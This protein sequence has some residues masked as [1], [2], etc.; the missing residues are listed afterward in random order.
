MMTRL[1]FLPNDQTFLLLDSPFTAREVVEAVRSGSWVPP[2]PYSTFLARQ[3]EQPLLAF[4]Q[5]SLVIITTT[6]PLDLETK[7]VAAPASPRRS[8]DLLLTPRQHDVLQYM[9]EGMT[10]KEMAL[11]L[12]VCIRTVAMH[13]AAIKQRLGAS[14]RAQIV[15][16]AAVLGLCKPGKPKSRPGV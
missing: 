10:T 8:S 4:Q 2:E 9:A 3:Q 7:A 11:R 5:G 16:R 1:L 6:Q 12:G 13:V 14:T 15:G